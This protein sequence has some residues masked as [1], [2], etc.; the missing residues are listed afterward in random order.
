MSESGKV[1]NIGHYFEKVLD[2]T[3]TEREL[4]DIYEREFPHLYRVV[5]NFIKDNKLEEVEI[6]D[7]GGGNG[8]V[9][10]HLK[11]NSEFSDRIKAT[12]IDSNR[13]ILDENTAADVKILSDP[14][15][16]DGEDMFDIVIMRYVLQDKNSYEQFK[17]FNNIHHALK[18][19]GIFLNWH[20]SVENEDHK[21][22]FLT[23][24]ASDEINP[25]LNS[26]N[27]YWDTME[28]IFALKVEAGFDTEI[29]D[30][31]SSVVH[32]TLKLKYELSDEED[33]EIQEFLGEYNYI[34]CAL[35]VS[36]K[37]D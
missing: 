21:K 20:I 31:Y 37:L 14:A 30:F 1:K 4:Y 8:A 22:R 15:E 18:T 3:P 25:K 12:C 27:S 5:D 17:I 32:A 7:F 19:N 6:A 36:K 23:L 13:D 35:T 11:E 28:D 26:P 16:F 29:V 9:I 10:E 33:R 34:N 2:I 24:L